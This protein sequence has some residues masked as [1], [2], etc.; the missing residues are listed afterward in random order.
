MDETP[1]FVLAFDLGGTHLRA[2][3]IDQDGA[4][5][6]SVKHRTPVATTASDVVNALVAAARESESRLPAG[7][8]I[9]AVSVAVPGSVNAV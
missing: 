9:R 6:S 5:H 1:H 4:I 8:L 3:V 7:Q 2:A